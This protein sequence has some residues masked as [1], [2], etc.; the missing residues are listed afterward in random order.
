[1]SKKTNKVELT[2]VDE[3]VLENVARI[4]GEQSASA[5]ALEEV[6]R[7]RAAGEDAYI[8]EAPHRTLVVGPMPAA[9]DT[10]P[11]PGL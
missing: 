6:K 10:T 1:M 8:F 5:Q 9:P 11:A 3:A 2:L 7:R 4:M